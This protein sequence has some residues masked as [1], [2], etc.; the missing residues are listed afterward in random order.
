MRMQAASASATSEERGRGSPSAME[1]GH[2]QSAKKARLELAVANGPV[3]R[4][5]VVYEAGEIVPAEQG[6][7]T[8]V[9][10][11]MDVTVLHCPFCFLP[12]KPP[13]F[14]VRLHPLFVLRS[15]DPGRCGFLGVV[16]D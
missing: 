1:K 3:K 15:P 11:K 16:M 5:I 9:S 14:Q 4:E 13:V 6:P 10:V 12:F 7:T 8:E 2:D